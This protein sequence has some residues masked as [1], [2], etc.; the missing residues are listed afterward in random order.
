MADRWPSTIKDYL[1]QMVEFTTAC[2]I[3]NKIQGK[4]KYCSI[5]DFILANGRAY[6]NQPL[7]KDIKLRKLGE[8]FKN[9]Y[10]L[11]MMRPELTYVEGIV[12][13]IIPML[14]AWCVDKDG[15]VFDNTWGRNHKREN[16]KHKDFDPNREYFGV[17][18]QMQYIDRTLYSKRTY[19]IIDNWKDGFPL[20][21]GKDDISTG[22]IVVNDSLQVASA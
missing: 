7:P 19:G 12:W 17:P 1:T 8:C 6:R 13:N 14:H 5:E 9:A 15:N 21:S 16:S 20:L 4:F 11:A 22:K 10:Y 2:H 18:F 3:A